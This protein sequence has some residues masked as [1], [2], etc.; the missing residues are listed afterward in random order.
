MDSLAAPAVTYTT[1]LAQLDKSTDKAGRARQRILSVFLPIT[2]LLYVGTVALNPK[3]TDVVVSDTASAVKVLPIAAAHTAQL[4]LSGSLSLLA[5][6]GLAVSY[7][8]IAT[9]VRGRGWVIATVAALLGAV[10]AFC[11][12]VVNVHVGVDL[13]A[14]AA[15]HL[16]PGAAAR[17][18]VTVFNSPSSQVFTDVYFL[19]EYAAPLIMAFALWR[20]RSVPRWLAVLFP[21]ALI[22]AEMMPS[23]GPIVLLYMLPFVVAMVLLAARIWQAAARRPPAAAATRPAPRTRRGRAHAPVKS[24]ARSRQRSQAVPGTR[25][26]TWRRVPRPPRCGRSPE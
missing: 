6:G 20:S 23:I 19:S 1:A 2:A 16:P 17:F 26:R 21:A 15:A 7:P 22:G 18:L 9:L 12:I 4:Y 25:R 11:G 8:A 5:L 24:M 10:G 14:A 3:G 13:A